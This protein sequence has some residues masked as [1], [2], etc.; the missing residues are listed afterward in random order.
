MPLTDFQETVIRRMEKAGLGMVAAATKRHW[1][2]GESYYIDSRCRAS[3]TL[4][5]DF[6]RGNNIATGELAETK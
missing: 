2:L 3:R 4:R 5:R 6:K 1:E